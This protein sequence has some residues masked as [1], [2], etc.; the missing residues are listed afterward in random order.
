MPV[1]II[2]TR[3][4]NGQVHINGPLGDKIFCYGM[5]EVAKDIVRN[6]KVPDIIQPEDIPQSVK[7]KITKIQ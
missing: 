4:E 7:N 1:S 3:E 5:L 6:Y 2:I